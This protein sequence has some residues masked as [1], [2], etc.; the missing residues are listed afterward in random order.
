MWE[1]QTKGSI[2]NAKKLHMIE[3]GTTWCFY[4]VKYTS[5]NCHYV[6]YLEYVAPF[7]CLIWIFLSWEKQNKKVWKILVKVIKR[8]PFVPQKIISL[9]REF[10]RFSN[11]Q[12]ALIFFVSVIKLWKL[13]PS[14]CLYVKNYDGEW[15]HFYLGCCTQKIYSKQVLISFHHQ[16][17]RKEMSRRFLYLFSQYMLIA[18]KFL[19]YHLCCP[20]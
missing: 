18:L 10:R 11:S 8:Q 15:W 20:S 4:F 2:F 16:L 6:E 13:W 1:K 14:S 3:T 7:A 17:N 12:T 9:M 19:P 5:W